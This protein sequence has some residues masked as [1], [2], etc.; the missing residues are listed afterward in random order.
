MPSRTLVVTASRRAS[1]PATWPLE[2]SS[3][4]AV[5]QRPLPSMMMET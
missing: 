1:T 2:R 4:R 3:P 5:A